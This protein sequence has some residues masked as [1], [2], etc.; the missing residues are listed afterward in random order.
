LWVRDLGSLNGTYVN[1]QKVTETELPPNELLTIGT[2]TFR[3]MYE[4]A[5][6]DATLH[7]QAAL[8]TPAQGPAAHESAST[9]RV[10][11]P[12]PAEATLEES[13]SLASMTSLGAL[14]NA[15]HELENGDLENGELAEDDLLGLDDSDA[16]GAMP[17][18]PLYAA[19]SASHAPA[20]PPQLYPGAPMI[21]SMGVT[22]QPAPAFPPQPSAEPVE[23]EAA[24]GDD[25]DLNDFLKSL[26]K[27]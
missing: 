21:P 14:D 3:A 8:V 26:E 10:D 24:A 15:D 18:A 25:E 7:D 4:P 2:V 6:H 20:L 11:A 9:V 5:Q 13:G 23:E 16:D 1:N 19:D 12:V 27:K 17:S 22:P